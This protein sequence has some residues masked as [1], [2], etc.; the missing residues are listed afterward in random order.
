[1][2]DAVSDDETAPEP[3]AEPMPAASATP[4]STVP[5]FVGK[6]APGYESKSYRG[7]F[8]VL[9]LALAAVLAGAIGIFAVTLVHGSSPAGPAWS[10]WKPTSASAADMAGQIAAHVAPLYRLA[11]GGPQLVAVQATDAPTV[12]NV[13]VEDVALK[14]GSNQDYKIVP[15]KHSIVYTLC[16]LGTRCKI[17]TGTPSQARARLLRREAL[18]LSL[19]TFKYVDGVD[20]V[21]V[22]IPPPPEPNTNWALFFQDNQLKTE[23]SQPLG[24]TLPVAAGVRKLV[25]ASVVGN[26]G[27]ET[28]ERLTRPR[29][30]TSQYQQ[31][32]DGNAILVLDPVI[33]AG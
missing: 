29:W 23:L 20:S 22:H 14:G 13:P 26:A 18:E 33:A 24:Q 1:V 25:P 6:A 21:I 15:T 19:Y 11:P 9:Y 12:Q 30:F 5:P 28:I 32:P 10:V 17:A 31:L 7:R 3:V 2:A 8:A 4:A 16:G 27:A